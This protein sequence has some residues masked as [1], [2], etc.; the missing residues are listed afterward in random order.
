LPATSGAQDPFFSPD[1]R[2]LGFFADGKLKKISLA[3]GA[4]V[5]LGDVSEPRGGVWTA[6]GRIIFGASRAGGLMQIVETGGQAQRLTTPNADRGELRHERPFVSPDGRELLFSIATTPEEGAPVR[7]GLAP[8]GNARSPITW[9]SPLSGVGSAQ[10]GAS[11]LIVF[12]RGNELQAVTFDPIRLT[13][14][15]VP[16]TVVSPV[17][18]T[19]GGAQF[20]I[21]ASGSLLYV[22]AQPARSAQAPLAWMTPAG[23]TP[24]TNGAEP[25]AGTVLSPDGR[26]IAWTASDDPTRADLWIGDLQRGAVTRLTHDGLNVSPVWSP[27]GRTIY[28]SRRDGQRY[29]PMS[30]DAEG[31]QPSAL[32]P[33][34]REAFPSSASPDGLLVAVVEF[35]PETR[36]DIWAIPVRG[37]AGKAVVQSPFDDVEPVFDPAGRFLAY[38]SD[39]AGRWDVYIVRLSDN[40]RAVVSTSGGEPPLWSRDGSTLYYRSGSRLMSATVS[41]DDMRVGTPVVVMDVGEGDITGVAPDGRF[42]VHRHAVPSSSAV[43]VSEWLR[44]ARSLLLPPAATMPR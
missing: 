18:T 43:I 32:T 36:G 40:R 24:V 27:D 33:L 20:A 29:Q 10:F 2:W 39:E 41:A 11:D 42:L 6:D 13:L 19:V 23:S 26:R 16:Q 30:I 3:G 37:G 12:S 22:V 14:S 4:P 38:Q 17:N 7:V 25:S 34:D 35:G 15:G 21:S 8:L 44:E 31:G 28:F 1:G 9:S 5:T